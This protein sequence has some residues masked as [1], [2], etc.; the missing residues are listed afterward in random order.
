MNFIFISPHFPKHYWNFCDRLKKNGV[1]VLGIGDSPYD[2]LSD[3]L[4][5][6]L[7]EYYYLPHLDDYE[8]MVRAVGFFTFKYGKIDW[9]ESNN[10]FWL[11]QDAR[12]R[13]DFHVTTGEQYD[14][15]DRIKNKSAMKAY[16][17]KAGV[18]TA[19]LHKVTTF[20]AGRDFAHMVGYPVIV[21]PDNGVGACDTYKLHSD[22]ELAYFYATKP[23]SVPYVME[24]FINGQIFSYDAI[25]DSHSEPLFESTT[26]WPPSIMD[27]VLKQLDLAYYTAADVPEAL[28]WPC[29][30]QGVWRAQPLRSPRVLLP[31][32][33]QGRPR[34]EGRFRRPRGQ[35]APGGRLHAGHDELRTLDGCLP[36]LGRHGHDGPPH[37]AGLRPALLLCLR[38]PPRLLPLRAPP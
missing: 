25:L 13:T 16:Y 33:G 38:R 4:K 34:Q 1:N 37:P 19:R 6:A 30:G 14:H 35:H 27:I 3:E 18:P 10:E 2:A 36:D 15:I 12:L 26:A 8:Q 29:D 31:R 9:I 32:R 21:K 24:E 11:E 5:N 17:A 22:D 28:R 7:T 20:E 23:Q